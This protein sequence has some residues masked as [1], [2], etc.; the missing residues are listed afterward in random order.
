MIISINDDK[1]GIDLLTVI[2]SRG[3]YKFYKVC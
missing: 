3:D 1:L 2:N